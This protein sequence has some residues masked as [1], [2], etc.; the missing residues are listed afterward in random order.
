M[1]RDDMADWRLRQ[2]NLAKPSPYVYPQMPPRFRRCRVFMRTLF[3]LEWSGVIL[4]AL[5]GLIL[6]GVLL[7]C[8]G[9]AFDSRL[10]GSALFAL[11]SAGFMLS[12]PL[13]LACRA[14]RRT[15]RHFWRCPC[16]GLALPYYA[17]PL[18]GLD[19]LREADC[20]YAMEHLRIR[21]VRPSC[22]PLILPSEC[23][24]CRAKFFGVPEGLSAGER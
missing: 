14:L 2:E 18:R 10:R 4:M 23:P 12:V 1:K 15:P 19:E 9:E 21:Y 11:L 13:A 17:P 7:A 20:V 22:C 8:G 16:C 5:S 3:L 6:C 24:V